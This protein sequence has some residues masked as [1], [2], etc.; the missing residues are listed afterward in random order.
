[1]EAFSQQDGGD[2]AKKVETIYKWLIMFNWDVDIVRPFSFY[3]TSGFNSKEIKKEWIQRKL[4]VSSRTQQLKNLS[5]FPGDAVYSLF[6]KIEIGM[7]A[8]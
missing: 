7:L 2:G 5:P 1:M 8:N 6:G 4:G 3:S